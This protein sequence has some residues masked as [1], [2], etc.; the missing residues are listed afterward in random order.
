MLDTLA[1]SPNFLFL[2]SHLFLWPFKESYSTLSSKCSIEYFLSWLIR[3]FTL[4]ILF[5]C[6]LFLFHECNTFS[7]LSMI[8]I[9][10]GLFVFVVYFSA[11]SIVSMSSQP[12][13]KSLFIKFS[14]FIVEVFYKCLVILKC[15]FMIKKWYTKKLRGDFMCMGW[16][17]PQ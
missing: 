14:F 4:I 8:I 2:H 16:L 7:K 15:L 17:A 1:W 9:S 5:H 12:S 13:K 11:P 10:I 6:I 3:F